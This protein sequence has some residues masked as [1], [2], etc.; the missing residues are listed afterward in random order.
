MPTVTAF[1][2]PRGRERTEC[3]GPTCLDEEVRCHHCGEPVRAGD[4]HPSC[5]WGG[6]WLCTCGHCTR[7]HS[8]W[9]D[10]PDSD[11]HPGGMSGFACDATGCD[12]DSPNPA[13]DFFDDNP[14]REKMP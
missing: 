13:P 11:L 12:C 6:R 8:T 4:G 10:L 7:H 1:D 14:N 2:L 5:G 3:S 9:W